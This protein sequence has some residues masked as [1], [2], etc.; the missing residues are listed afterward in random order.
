MAAAAGGGRRKRRVREPLNAF[1]R[2]MRSTCA[3]DTAGGGRAAGKAPK[4]ATEKVRG[5]EDFAEQLQQAQVADVHLE[6]AGRT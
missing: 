1:Q 6:E 5:E 3:G 4:E 2:P